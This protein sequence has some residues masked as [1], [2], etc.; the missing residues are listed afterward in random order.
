MAR[1]KRHSK[2][3]KK[4]TPEPEARPGP[5]HLR[6]RRIPWGA[7][8]VVV[9]A[10]AGVL[11]IL[12][13][14]YFGRDAGPPAPSSIQ[15]VER[16]RPA[17]TPGD[18]VRALQRIQAAGLILNDHEHIQSIEEVP[19]LLSAMDDL[20][21]KRVSL[22]GSSWFTITLNPSVGFTRYDWNNE[23]IMQ[24]SRAYPDR[25]EA[26]PT[27]NPQDPDKLEKFKDLVARG[28]AG[29]KL[30][31]GHGYI[32]AKTNEY[33][34][35]TMAMD[36]PSM[37]PVY[38]FCE[39]NFIPVCLHVNP[40]AKAPG[41][42]DEFIAVLTQFPDLKLVCPHF[43]LSSIKSH[44]LEEF[45]DTF[46]NLYSDIGFGW[47]KFFEA[48]I[49]RISKSP[50]K[51]QRI[52]ERYPDRFFFS[53]DLV[54]TEAKMKSTQWIKDHWQTYLDM[55]TQRTYTSPLIPDETL[56]GLELPPDLLEGVLYR[57][58]EAFMAAKP[59]GTK[60]TRE[61]NWDRMT[62]RPT[63]RHPGQTFPPPKK[64]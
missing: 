42:A 56:K 63:K 27:I 36:D 22:M 62:V 33:I 19:K 48:G 31:L 24:I 54:V 16:D 7:I 34:F 61:I 46:P 59:Q 2:G 60:L 30:Y 64:K 17:R 9:L 45:L 4:N 18:S 5:H 1:R 12:Q 51:F 49:K 37:L 21:I 23:Q 32:I 11:G 44:R 40:S 13:E 8:A 50:R 14:W 26:W 15:A 47:A 29:L 55:L 52:F 38:A 35:H 39:E 58:F 28:A 6:I 3:S 43:M 57:N 41:F 20:G 25:F 53:G 10:I